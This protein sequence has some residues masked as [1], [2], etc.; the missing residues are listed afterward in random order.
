LEPGEYS[1]DL[2]MAN[3]MRSLDYSNH[4]IFDTKTITVEERTGIGPSPQPSPKWEGAVYDLSGR[5]IDSS[6]FT[7]HSSLKKGLYVVDRKKV[8]M[9]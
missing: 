8:M 3:D 2:L 1:I 7:L 5:K 4:F 6:L 9:K